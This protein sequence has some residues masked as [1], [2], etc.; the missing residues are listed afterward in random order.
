MS[1][2]LSEAK[3]AAREAR[4]ERRRK[5]GN[6]AT[7]RKIHHPSA[8]Y[9]VPEHLAD[10]LEPSDPPW[11]DHEKRR[12]T[13]LAPR[14]YEGLSKPFYECGCGDCS[15][16]VDP[17]AD[18]SELF[19]DVANAVDVC[20]DP[21]PVA[22]GKA[23]EIYLAYQK[24]AWNDPHKTSRL[25]HTQDRN[26]RML[27]AERHILSEMEDPTMIFLSLRLSPVEEQ[28]G[29][30]RWIPPSILGDRLGDAWQNVRAVLGPQL[31]DYESQYAAITAMT[32]SAATPHRH[33]A[34]YV[35]DPDDEVGIGVAESA[36]QSHVN[37]CKGAHPEDHPVEPDQS[38]AGMI[39]HDIPWA[40][41]VPEETLLDL[42][43]ARGEQSFS[44]PSIPLYYMSIQQPH[45][46]LKNVYD[47]T[48]DINADSINV[49]GA[50][51]AW[52]L[53]WREYSS[54]EG[55]TDEGYGE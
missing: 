25:E 23:R 46:A 6:Y 5:A 30:R 17:L 45:W 10:H 48:S 32:T 37:N 4:E 36:V 13:R 9:R 38:D 27:G 44:L 15:D 43:H 8:D 51:I 53:S 14:G 16:A 29:E 1:F 50:A 39:F 26:G 40:E 7:T 34:I 20:P 42:F 41:Q 2:T 24:A 33:A 49:D 31:R 21:R 22:V 11:I 18:E 19:R 55:F 52:A 12:Q 28:Y 54:S 47:G 35:D 3:Q